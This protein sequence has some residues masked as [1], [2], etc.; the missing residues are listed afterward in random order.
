[1]DDMRK[2][3]ADAI[4]STPSYGQPPPAPVPVPQQTNTMMNTT[5]SYPPSP[6][7]QPAMP[8]WADQT[9]HD[10]LPRPK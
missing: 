1:M 5:P 8:G 3:L 6:T 7:A 10:W 4:M 9:Y 2:R